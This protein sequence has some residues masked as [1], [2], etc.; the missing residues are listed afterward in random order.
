MKYPR[1]RQPFSFEPQ[2]YRSPLSAKQHLKYFKIVWKVTTKK[3]IVYINK[4]QNKD[5]TKHQYLLQHKY[6]NLHMQ[7]LLKTVSRQQ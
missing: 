6:G 3:L 1:P 2:E 4:I 5:C 7:L